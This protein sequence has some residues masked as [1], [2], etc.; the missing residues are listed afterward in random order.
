[1]AGARFTAWDPAGFCPYHGPDAQQR[2]DDTSH[3]LPANLVNRVRGIVPSCVDWVVEQVAA[4]AEVAYRRANPRPVSRRA[5]SSEDEA[6][7]PMDTSRDLH[8]SQS[9]PMPDAEDV[10]EDAAEELSDI[11]FGPA[12]DPSAASAD[13][14]MR[15][16]SHDDARALELGQ[17]GAENE[18]LYIV[19]F[20]DDIHSSAHLFKA[21]RDFFG[22]TVFYTDKLLGTL[23]RV[24]RQYG[25]LVVWG[26]MEMAAD[27]GATQVHL[28]LDG[29]SVAA[30]RIGAVALERASRLTKHGLFCSI[31][32]GKELKV[33]QRA[34]YVLQWLSAVARS[35]D[36]LCQTVAEC[37]L[38]NRHLVPLLR[39]DFKMSARVTK[40]WY[41]LLLTLLAVPT[42]KSHLAA[43]YCDT[44]RN[45]TAKYARGMGVLERSGYTLSVQFLNRVTYVVDLVKRRDLLGKLGKAILETLLVASEPDHLYGRLDPNHSVLTHR[46]YSPC[47]SDLK[48]V[49][50]VKGMPRIIACEGASFLDDWIASLSLAQLMDPHVWRHWTLGHVESESRGWVG[51][52]NASI[53]LGSLF[54]R[55]LGWADEDTS[56]IDDPSSPYARGLLPC[57]E[58][59]FRI[60]R[61]GVDRWQKSEMVSYEPTLYTAEVEKYKRCP[62]SL[63]FSTVAASRD[64]ACAMRQ[65]P[66]S[67]VTPFSF[68][69][70]LHRFVASCLREL[71]IRTDDEAFGVAAL[72]RLLRERLPNNDYDG[73][74][75]G[76]MEFPLLVLSRATQVRGGMWRRNGNGLNDQVLNYAEPPFCRTMRDADLLMVQF[77]VMGRV[78]NL[79]P[80]SRPSSDVGMSFFVNLLIH[81]LGLFDF[82]GLA[83]APSR[84][85]PRYM[86]E[87]ENGLYPREVKGNGD[88]DDELPWTYAPSRDAASSFV[89]MEEFLH[90]IIMF[91]SEL[92]L[93][94]P[95]DRAD[96]TKQAK[97]KLFREVV[98]RLAS[99]PKT[100]SELSEV[101]HVLSHWDNTLLSEEGKLI[102]PDDATGAALGTVLSEMA[103]RKVS[104]GKLE[105]DKW[106]MQRS[107]WD[108]YDPAF[109][110]ISLR[111]HQTA[112]ENR[113]KPK[114]DEQAMFGWEP[115]AYA[116]KPYVAHSYFSRLRRDSTA[117]AT[118]LA[119]TYRVLH[120][121]CRQN[122][123]RDLSNLLGKA[124][125]ECSEKSETAVARA[126]HIL[127]LGAYAWSDTA[128]RDDLQW[129]EKG[130]GSAGSIFFDR[131]DS[132]PAPT[133]A[134]WIEATLLVEPKRLLDCDW[135]DGEDKL[136]LLL[137]RLA[138]KGGLSGGFM[139]QDPSVRSGAAWLCDF[140]VKF[141]SRAEDLVA[142]KKA[143]AATADGGEEESEFDRRKRLAKENR[144]KEMAKMKAQAAKFASMMEVDLGDSEDE[145]ATQ[146]GGTAAAP[147]TP[148]TP[149]TRMNSVGS[150]AESSAGSS[151]MS[152]SFSERSGPLVPF[153]ADIGVAEHDVIPPRL[154]R[155][156]PLCII[157]NYEESTDTRKSENEAGEGQRKR[158]RR[159]TENALG[160]VGYAQPS[161]VLKGGGGPPQDPSSPFSTVGDFVGTHV[162]LCG[163]AVHSECCESYLTTVLHREDRL[164]GKRDEFRCPLC[165][166]LSNCLVPFIDVGVDWIESPTGSNDGQGKAKT[167]IESESP[168]DID[169][170]SKGSLS[171]HD[172]L[173]GTPWWVTNQNGNV[174]WDGQSAFIDRTLELS[175]SESNEE[176]A[177][178]RK[179]ARRRPVR[180]LKKKDL[181]AAWSAMMRTPR[182][183][184][185]KL[186]P[187]SSSGL[188]D[189][190]VS[191]S[192]VQ[193][194]TLSTP[195]ATESAGE[196]LV[197]RRFMDQLSDISYR[198]DSKRLGDERL[199][200]VFGEF[201]HY[202][203][204]KYAY[205]MGNQYMGSSPVDVS[206]LRGHVGFSFVSCLT[207]LPSS[208]KSGHHACSP[209]RCRTANGRKCRERSSCRSFCYRSNRSHTAAAA[210]RS[211]PDATI[212]KAS[213][214]VLE[215][216]Q[217]NA[218]T[219]RLT[220]FSRNSAL[221]TWFVVG[222]WLYYQSR[223]LSPTTGSSRLMAVS[224][225][226]VISR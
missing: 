127:T 192:R 146:D 191:I 123:D 190:S 83:K 152:G 69:L 187:R 81:R 205:N 137:Q 62:C 211:K 94:P 203:V 56:P 99:G 97:W 28:W 151:V 82:L 44:Y 60:L 109:Y 118:V 214:Q 15:E 212:A 10:F 70:P 197:W 133:A 54:E 184:R 96:H 174:V 208:P 215:R 156:R 163:H 39:A 80:R 95:T 149:V 19:L 204:E 213:R 147:S 120:L 125:Y 210:S 92:P 181:Y 178:L 51:A 131:A 13:R 167:D 21:L 72:A 182:F 158:S 198:A 185:R 47:V 225:S 135:Y 206:M 30:T 116:P 166:R 63:P 164:I 57:V 6:A 104:R 32:T 134:D 132:E 73:L 52:F 115:R 157:C 141:S 75:L 223:P 168:M 200:L 12:F 4:T 150:S 171:L 25:H 43:A 103:E 59:T 144:M 37:I 114:A 180:S 41:S 88:T 79:S 65:M 188:R 50:N 17:L 209:K 5:R 119:A 24:L 148:H 68:H 222:S 160:F 89:L 138:T 175:S 33:E 139:A 45:V 1:M 42:F 58:M 16:V 20:A 14:E 177:G 31:A 90:L 183:V 36:P 106:E 74:Y 7:S 111:N 87:S 159:K 170:P 67:Q 27:C 136:L 172:F 218:R 66:V 124:A 64:A 93:P 217:P 84:D 221:A 216:R 199:H 98:H 143:V 2:S 91:T 102:N 107:A 130:G 196:T 161:T 29:D 129:R 142:P 9:M 49:L 154:L 23:V 117:D 55:L 220:P 38:P 140:A 207:S 128:S 179:P 101:Q 71:C 22:A 153:S 176:Q 202:V 78:H 122:V 105:P 110:H 162:A 155:V 100:H 126:L 169:S 194:L 121:H 85:I 40:A 76:L 8:S 189:S 18:G 186:R 3:A 53:S 86:T 195:E 219:P 201:R 34:V 48:C 11:L 61:T 145:A 26:T 193:E 35:C 226:S 77:A 112:A 108:S 113:P 224:A 46:R 165:Q 173:S